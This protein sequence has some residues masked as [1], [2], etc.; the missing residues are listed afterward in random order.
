MLVIRCGPGG[1]ER[2][3]GGSKKGELGKRDPVL[4]CAGETGELGPGRPSGESR[5]EITRAG[6]LGPVIL[7]PLVT[8][9]PRIPRV[10]G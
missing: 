8:W 5:S 3:V 9:G 4:T 2:E 7:S 1:C 10:S 6:L